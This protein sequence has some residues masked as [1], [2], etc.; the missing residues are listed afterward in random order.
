VKWVEPKDLHLTLKF[1]GDVADENAP[2]AVEILRRCAE[3]VEPFELR[4]QG[5]GAFPNLT[6]PR[7]LFADAEDSPRTAHELAR[8]LNRE[9]TRAGV[10]R[11]E[12]GFRCHVTIGRVRKPSPMPALAKR[13]EGLFD[14]EFGSMT[15][16]QVVLMK[17]DLTPQGPVYTPIERAKLGGGI[18]P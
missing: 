8:R 12:R 17:S 13:L 1:L 2:K 5:A 4:V 7:V 6:R 3:G 14:K 10:E 11:E 9:M 18:Q 15:V 16:R